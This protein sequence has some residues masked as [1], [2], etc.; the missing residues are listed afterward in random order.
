[1]KKIKKNEIISKNINNDKK[2]LNPHLLNLIKFKLHPPPIGSFLENPELNPRLNFSLLEPVLSKGKKIL[3]GDGSFS[4]VYLFQNKISKIKYAIK[5]M[6]ISS[7]LKKTNNKDL[8][9]NEINIQSKINHPNIIRLYNYFEDKNNINIFLVL[10]YASQ[11]TLFDYIRY[12]KGLNE[13]E[14]FYYFIQAVNAIYFLHKN[15]IIHRD[16]KPENLLINNNNILK[17]CDF[18]WS[19]YLNNNKRVTFC[20]TVE[21]MAPEIVKKKEYD[22]SI[23][24]WSLGVLLY[25]LIHSHSPFVAKDLNINKIE[26]NIISKEL[27]FKKG[28]SLE[29][30]DLIEKLLIKDAENRIKIENIYTHPFVLK[31]V[32]MINNYINLNYNN[33]YVMKLEQN[34]KNNQKEEINGASKNNIRESF[35]EF[36][37]I[38]SEPEAS[39]ILVNLD[40]AYR[41]LS[42]INKN[43][44][45]GEKQNNENKFKNI[46]NLLDKNVKECSRHKKSLSLNES[47]LEKLINNKLETNNNE[48]MNKNKLLLKEISENKTKNINKDNLLKLIIKKTKY[49]NP[50]MRKKKFIRN[51]LIEEYNNNLN[52]NHHL[53]KKGV[54]EYSSQKIKENKSFS[55]NQLISSY[56]D[57]NK[58]YIV[59]KKLDNCRNKKINEKSKL[60]IS[61]KLNSKNYKSIS[62]FNKN[63]NVLYN[64]HSAYLNYSSYG[65][66][67]NNK[68]EKSKKKK[69]I[70][71]S[72]NSLS[73]GIK[74]LFVSKVLKK[75]LSKE[76]FTN[77]FAF[78]LSNINIYNVCS[79]NFS[80]IN[81]NLLNDSKSFQQINAFFTEN[82]KNINNYIISKSSR[83]IKKKKQKLNI[84][85]DKSNNSNSNSDSKRN[86]NKTKNSLIKNQK[87]FFRNPILNKGAKS[88]RNIKQKF[89]NNN[90][91]PLIIL[92]IKK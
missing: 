41:K 14:A 28:V 21:Y 44:D 26:N 79:S 9:I 48:N 40:N 75:P 84:M 7:F 15:K 77:K 23:D 56:N 59:K 55:K 31:Y 13:I 83:L 52:K 39:K 36:D 51:I 50:N 35:S 25:E 58:K 22:F 63:N 38:P 89:L 10:E 47:N 1:M 4:K 92:N 90:S 88:C 33:T 72:I 2:T 3:I 5:K 71:N 32:N 17:L 8:I 68:K 29:C 73:K 67:N 54:N 87:L 74:D 64:D 16:I 53:T 80:A 57:K 60:N 42:E 12:K 34:K 91:I 30:R 62:F 49:E 46:K 82:Q 85:N 81:S 19:V 11:K 69:I 6:N 78:N 24:V 45:S 66:I 61:S 37:S 43:I 86:I 18:G 20:G 27:R 70:I 65:N 76:S